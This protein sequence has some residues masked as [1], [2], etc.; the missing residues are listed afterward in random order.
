MSRRAWLLLAAVAL[1]GGAA[2]RATLFPV[3]RS[4]PRPR[5]LALLAD[6]AV[7]AVPV[8]VVLASVPSGTYRLRSG[9]APMLVHYWAPWERQG[10]TQAVMLDSLA[11]DPA[12]AGLD[13]TIVCFEPFP[14]VARFAARHRL[15]T[16][17]LLDRER[18]LT[19]A[20]PCPVMPYTVALD[21]HGRVRIE[22]PGLVAWDADSTRRALRALLAPAG[23]EASRLR[24]RRPGAVS[25]GT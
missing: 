24:D 21:A 7:R 15:T 8:D 4:A 11:R 5:P 22:Q 20:L 10:R 12:F 18:A 19:R 6:S 17:V 1:A 25:S 14:T 2:W 13:V 23:V 16:R 3:D 9:T